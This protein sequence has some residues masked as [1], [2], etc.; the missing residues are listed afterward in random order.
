MQGITLE[1][2]KKMGAIWVERI[3]KG[4]AEHESLILEADEMELKQYLQERIRENGW[5]GSLVDFYYG[6]LKEEEQ[7]IVREALT[8]AQVRYIEEEVRGGETIYFPLTEELFEI[9]FHL[10][11]N[12]ILFSTFYFVKIPCTVWSN[13]GKKFVVFR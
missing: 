10:S 5:E 12:E 2:L 11:V 13:Y 7:R 4:F 3:E 8:E 9:T 1:S 6:R